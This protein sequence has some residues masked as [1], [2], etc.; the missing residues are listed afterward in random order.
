MRIDAHQ[1]FW[2]YDAA[3]D[4]WIT[5]EMSALKRD[6]LPDELARPLAAHGF[7]GCIAIEATPS[8][9]HTRFLLDLARGHPFIRGVVGWVDLLAHDL[10]RVLDTLAGEPLL[11][12]VRHAAQAEADDYLARDDVAHG[13]EQLGAFGFTYDILIYARQLPAAVTLVSRLPSQQFVVDHVAKPRIREGTLAPWAT[14]LRELAQR[15]NV[16][17]KISGL[18]TEADW[19]SWRPDHLRPYLDVT[20]D[21]FGADRV[22]F[23]SDW[24][25]CL[26]AA[27]YA[28]VVDVVEDYAA[29]LTEAERR[30]L[31]GGNAARFYHLDRRG[32]PSLENGRT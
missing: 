4:T 24:P 31:F 30:G 21:A 6:F 16:Y 2:H 14:R 5:A 12:G 13:I 22:M 3:R 10:D 15:P 9:E 17:C 28:A 20:L 1:H 8:I 27:D 19:L 29:A 18:V 25:V 11:K 26:L 23:G 32:V 7:D